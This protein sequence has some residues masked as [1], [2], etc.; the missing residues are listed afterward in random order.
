MDERRVA[1]IVADMETVPGWFTPEEG[2]YLA[3]AVMHILHDSESCTIVEVGSYKG[4]SAV[5][6]GNM[7]RELAPKSHIYCID[8]FEAQL[9]LTGGIYEDPTYDEF[10][11][12]IA[13]RQLDE[14]VTPIV[15]KSTD[16][17][18]GKGEI[19]LLHIDAL[20]DYKSVTADFEHY[21]EYM[22]AGGLVLFHDRG[23]YPGVTR[24]IDEYVKGR[25]LY[26]LGQAF[27]LYLLHQLDMWMRQI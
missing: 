24:A 26:P 13:S 7:V 4:R 16:V 12:N 22:S 20:H 23:V 15:K 6:L 14:W 21:I 27:S 17:E 10:K 18:W 1:E 2:R 25:R 3:D 8:P 5:V 9:T 19:D 11:S